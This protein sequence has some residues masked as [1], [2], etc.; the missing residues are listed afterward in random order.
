MAEN[1]AAAVACTLVPMAPP[2]H[3]RPVM[4]TRAALL[5]CLLPTVALAQNITFSE[6]SDLRNG[7]RNDQIINIAECLGTPTRD[8]IS[9][10]S[11]TLSG[12]PVQGTRYKVYA[13]TE[14]CP[15]PTGTFPTNIVELTNGFQQTNGS[16]AGS[17][18][19][20]IDVRGKIIE[21]LNLGACATTTT[22]NLCVTVYE[23]SSETV[24]NINATAQLKVDLDVPAAPTDVVVGIGD[25][26]LHVS[27]SPGSG[28][29]VGATAYTAVATPAA[30]QTGCNAGGTPGSC[31]TTG[32]TSCD[33]S[34]LTNNACYEVTVSARSETL[35][36]GPAS[37]PP[38]LGI[39]LPVEDFW[40]RYL[41][42]GGR[43]QGGCGGSAGALALLALAPLAPRLRRRRP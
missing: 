11:W 42:A 29:T 8:V 15:T 3:N 41:D 31:T 27:W 20:T 21:G 6:S 1:L 18:S 35:N 30:A 39:P 12:T 33:I 28:G 36:T 43:E 13:T 14:S 32:G 5:L 2:L 10:S 4:R 22:V 26:R 25:G 24:V 17:L 16:P 40:R 23:A 19:T 37:D 7:G 9:L 38:V 34:G